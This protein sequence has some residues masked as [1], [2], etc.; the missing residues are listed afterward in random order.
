VSSIDVGI[1]AEPV[2]IAVL[3]V[4]LPPDVSGEGN[5]G[6]AGVSMKIAVECWYYVCEE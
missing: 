2:T 1:Y 4:T 5:K 6:S 3:N